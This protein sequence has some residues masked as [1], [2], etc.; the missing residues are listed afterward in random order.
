MQEL[1]ELAN[2]LH[3]NVDTPNE[4]IVNVID[5]YIRKEQVS[6]RK[7]KFNWYKYTAQD[8]MRPQMC[9]VFHDK[10][11]K[12]ASDGGILIALK[13]TYYADFEGKII[14][15]DGKIETSEGYYKY[16]NWRDVLYAPEG[17]GEVI[18]QARL[19]TAINRCKIVRKAYSK[20]TLP[21][22]HICIK[23]NGRYFNYLKVELW[24]RAVERANMSTFNVQ[25]QQLQTEN[26]NGYA[27]VMNSLVDDEDKYTEDRRFDGYSLSRDKYSML[28]YY[29][30]Y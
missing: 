15:K 21:D 6:P 10:G 23:I 26:E 18:N 12:V 7:S 28:G 9:C 29:T 8:K 22:A 4:Y 1:Q 16:P 20:K 5:R 2:R 27:L 11:Y 24:L 13:E 17:K 25:K 19:E 14:D 30:E 3:S